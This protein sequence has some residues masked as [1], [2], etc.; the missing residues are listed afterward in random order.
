[1]DHLCRPTL[2]QFGG[3]VKKYSPRARSWMGYELPFDGH[4]V[5]RVLTA[6]K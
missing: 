2:V 6:K 1:M 3:T 4:T 5:I